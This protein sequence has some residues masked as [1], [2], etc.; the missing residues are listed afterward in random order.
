MPCLAAWNCE[1]SGA[2]SALLFGGSPFYLCERQSWRA[3]SKGGR[4]GGRLV[5]AAS[6]KLG[7]AGVGWSLAE[8]VCVLFPQSCLAFTRLLA[9][10]EK[11]L[12]K[13]GD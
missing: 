8:A 4:E 2:G 3:V 12:E 1:F 10:I 5:A 11:H 7:W 6:R 13:P 9:M